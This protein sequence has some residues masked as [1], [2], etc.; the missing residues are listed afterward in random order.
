M[1]L[2]LSAVTPAVAESGAVVTSGDF[3][4]FAAGT[5]AGYDIAGHATMVHNRNQTMVTI[6]VTGLVPGEQVVTDGATW[7]TDGRAV[8]VVGGPVDAPG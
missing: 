2:L 4:T 1:V 7:L 3:S 5:A 6:H 8:R